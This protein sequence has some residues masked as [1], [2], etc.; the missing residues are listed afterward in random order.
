MADYFNPM[1]S[2]LGNKNGF[3]QSGLQTQ[4]SQLTW[5]CSPENQK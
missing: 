1:A 4:V 2:T 3:G 5:V